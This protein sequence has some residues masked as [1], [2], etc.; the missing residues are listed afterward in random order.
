RSWTSM[1]TPQLDPPAL[2]AGHLEP[3]ALLAE[4]QVA[5]APD[6]A[7]RPTVPVPPSVPIVLADWHLDNNISWYG[8][9]LYG[10]TGACGL[11]PGGARGGRIQPVQ[12]P[13]RRC[14][15]RPADRFWH[16]RDVA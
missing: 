4:A 9:G 6:G 15:D 11:V 12:P 16:R 8:P 13:R 2:S 3:D 5:L 7:P 10:H 1:T 14:P